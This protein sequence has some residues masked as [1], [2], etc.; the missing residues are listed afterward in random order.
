LIL[1]WTAHEPASREWFVAALLSYQAVVLALMGGG[2]WVLAT[3]P[4]GRARIAQEWLIGLACLVIA[5]ACLN[6]PAHFGMTVLIASFFLLALR[7]VL[8]AEAAGL[9]LWLAGMRGY[10]TAA[11]IVTGI[12][13]LIRLII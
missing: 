7:D 6:V 2:H 13:A 11:A 1:I 5:W 10:I 9:P 8:M 4:Y 12:L 3:G